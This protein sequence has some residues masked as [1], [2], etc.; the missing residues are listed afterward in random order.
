MAKTRGGPWWL[1]VPGF[2]R[3]PNK[4]PVLRNSIDFLF[5]SRCVEEEGRW[6]N[7]SR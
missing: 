1:T 2:R 5:G 3:A 7:Y 4:N 6:G